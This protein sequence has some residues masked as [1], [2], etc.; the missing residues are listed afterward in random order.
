MEKKVTLHEIQTINLTIDYMLSQISNRIQKQISENEYFVE[1]PDI[2]L[3]LKDRWLSKIIQN[4]ASEK[5]KNNSQYFWELN[6][7]RLR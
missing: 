4:R 1:N 2:Y 6:R 5:K 7:G 3:F